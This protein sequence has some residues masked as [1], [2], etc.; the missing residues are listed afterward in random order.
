MANTIFVPL[1]EEL[2]K[3][4]ELKKSDIESLQNW[5]AKQPFLP[6]ISDSEL[7][8]FLHSN[9]YLMEPTKTTIDTFYTI[10]THVPEFFTNRD[11]VGSKELRKMF[12]TVCIMPLEK[13][14]REGYA[15]IMGQLLDRDPA[16]YTYNDHIRDL[17]MCMDLWMYQEGTTNGHVICFDTAGVTVGHAARLN[18]MGLKKFLFYLQEGLPVRLKGLHF[19]NTSPA[20]DL[21]LSMMKPFMKKELLDMLHMHSS[22]DSVDKFIPIE[23][24]PNELGGK[25]GP[26]M[27]LH[28]V[29]IKKLESF[30][31]WFLD[32]ETRAKIDESKRPGKGKTA[33]DLFG[34]EGSFKKLDID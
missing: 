9:Y 13:R 18:P 23:I 33:T 20:M 12:N 31:D 24:L 26:L 34:V 29:Q 5:C 16:N 6:K 14:T 4:P 3:N 22:M 27:E 15:V 2:K 10:R 17:C 30:R 25:A 28:N 7:A 19:L 32:E 21:I 1:E 11:P 8:I